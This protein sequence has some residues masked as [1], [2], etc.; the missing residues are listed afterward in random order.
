MKHI[1][2]FVHRW[3]NSTFPNRVVI[4][5]YHR[6]ADLMHPHPLSVTREH[7]AEQLQVI[8]QYYEYISLQDL[9]S[10]LQSGRLPRKGI[11]VT[12]DDG[13]L[14]HLLLQTKILP[15]TLQL[16][17]GNETH[18]WSLGD[19]PAQQSAWLDDMGEYPTPRHR[20]YHDLRHLIRPMP[21]AQREAVIQQLIDWTDGAYSGRPERR[22]MNVN[23]MQRIS[24]S[25]LVE[26]GAHSVHH[27]MLAQQPIEIQKAE[28]SGS[29][30]QL[31]QML[32]RKISSFAY[33]YGKESA[34]DNK[35]VVCVKE[36]A[37]V[38]GRLG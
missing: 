18:E 17:L 35:T 19:C 11:V 28:I 29:K 32:G 1:R 9:K 6:I 23:E 26:I 30:L 33:P 36:A 2:S 4:L 20:C 22:V 34:V 24:H 10:K 27:L 8:K 7:F 15:P 25:G 12:F 16:H 37:C 38:C 21:L 31:E 5:L 3:H 13:Y 14:E